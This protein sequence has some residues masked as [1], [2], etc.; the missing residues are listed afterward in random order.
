MRRIATEEMTHA[1]AVAPFA[2]TF[3]PQHSLIRSIEGKE[4]G[5]DTEE[6]PSAL[7]CP[8]MTSPP[9]LQSSNAGVPTRKKNKGG[10]TI[11]SLRALV[12]TV[13]IR[14]KIRIRFL[15]SAAAVIILLFTSLACTRSSAFD[16][17]NPIRSITDCLD[18]SS[19]KSGILC[20]LGRARHAL[21]F[22]R[23]S[24]SPHS[25]LG[26]KVAIQP[27]VKH[28]MGELLGGDVGSAE[29]GEA[30]EV[31]LGVGEVQM[32]G[33]G[34][35]EGDVSHELEALVGDAALRR[36]VLRRGVGEGLLCQPGVAKG[37]TLGG[38]RGPRPR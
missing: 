35:A 24:R 8:G 4:R 29:G 33:D 28:D 20:A 38:T 11:S 13:R 25:P 30:A 3:V 1:V 31:Y 14:V 36:G 32:V 21:S 26:A 10:I 2:G 15:T 27:A 12:V 9:P 34:E 16:T 17:G 18:L 19:L 37:V 23:F 5:D 7:T 22:A 6:E